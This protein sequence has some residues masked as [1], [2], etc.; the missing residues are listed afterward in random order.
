MTRLLPE[1]FF[2]TQERLCSWFDELRS[3]AGCGPNADTGA[4]LRA[5]E[6]LSRK[7]ETCEEEQA[8][9]ARGKGYRYWGDFYNA[10]MNELPE[11]SAIEIPKE[12]NKIPVGWYS[13]KGKPSYDKCEKRLIKTQKII[14]KFLAHLVENEETE[15]A[16]WVAETRSALLETFI[17]SIDPETFDKECLDFINGVEE[18][19][20]ETTWVEV[21]ET[22]TRA[23]E[24]A[25]DLPLTAVEELL[26]Y[27]TD[28]GVEITKKQLNNIE[29]SEWRKHKYFTYLLTTY[30]L[31]KK[32]ATPEEVDKTTKSETKAL[33]Y[34]KCYEPVPS[35][36]G[37]PGSKG[38][39]YYPHISVAMIVSAMLAVERLENGE[40]ENFTHKEYAEYVT[41]AAEAT[42]TLTTTT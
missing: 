18:E 1:S 32:R 26:A 15:G 39:I 40:G 34:W 10:V 37:M 4:V 12:Y 22:A 24:L 19:D 28:I 13:G 38:R 2:S 41:A 29:G 16:E 21:A 17:E 36:T 8:S 31:N 6:A 7:L 42:G 5:V 25:N 27:A 14:R 11:T 20:P 33:D 3:V 23:L 30:T 35:T 9:V